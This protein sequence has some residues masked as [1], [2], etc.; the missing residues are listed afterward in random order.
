MLLRKI[1]IEMVDN[2]KILSKIVTVFSEK[3]PIPQGKLMQIPT[4]EMLLDKRLLINCQESGDGPIYT[5]ETS[6]QRSIF[7][8]YY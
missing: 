6:C 2:S 5:E 7:W 8:D 1:Q 4:S 3:M